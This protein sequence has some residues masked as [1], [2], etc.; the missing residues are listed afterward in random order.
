MS[1]CRGHARSSQTL[2]CGRVKLTHILLIS[3]QS[4]CFAD[5][6]VVSATQQLGINGNETILIIAWVM[7][8]LRLTGGDYKGCG[9]VSAR[10]E[11]ARRGATVLHCDII[12]DHI[13]RTTVC[14]VGSAEHLI[15]DHAYEDVGGASYVPHVFHW[16]EQSRRWPSAQTNTS[17]ANTANTSRNC[18]ILAVNSMRTY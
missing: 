6:S 18:H 12:H 3:P 14:S 4:S 8:A 15:L 9:D 10:H 11:I 16:V 17:A 1:A 2:E 13:T 5:C 7:S